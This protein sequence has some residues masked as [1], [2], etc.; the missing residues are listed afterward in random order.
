MKR[1]TFTIQLKGGGR[2]GRTNGYV[3]PAFRARTLLRFMFNLERSN[4]DVAVGIILIKSPGTSPRFA[5]TMPL[6][7]FD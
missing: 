1:W 5:A 6:F 4:R 2:G 3:L 7:K